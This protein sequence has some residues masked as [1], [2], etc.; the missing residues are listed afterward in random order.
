METLYLLIPLS[1]VLIVLA[2]M[3]FIWSVRHGQFDDLEK[4]GWRILQEDETGT[5]KE[6]A[7]QMSDPEKQS[8]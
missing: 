5:T 4:E 8:E 1:L 6:S 7:V 3:A 2:C